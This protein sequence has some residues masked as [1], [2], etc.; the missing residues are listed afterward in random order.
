MCPCYDNTACQ[1]LPHVECD[2]RDCQVHNAIR[3]ILPTDSSLQS[4]YSPFTRNYA[5]LIITGYISSGTS[6]SITKI[7]KCDEL[8]LEITSLERS[9]PPHENLTDAR[10]L[11][12]R[13][14]QPIFEVDVSCC[15]NDSLF[16][17][18]LDSF[19]DGDSW[20]IDSQ[21]FHLHPDTDVVPS[22]ENA[23]VEELCDWQKV[24]Y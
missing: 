20:I 1:L 7:G 22:L 13:Y 5:K 2:N 14:G 8:D 12:R 16:F 3:I 10:V 18:P 23:I 19:T 15:E 24:I 17:G 9:H 6:S 4:E 21:S 11:A